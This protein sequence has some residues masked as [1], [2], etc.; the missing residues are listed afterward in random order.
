MELDEELP[1]S[2]EELERA[3]DM[4]LPV[5]AAAPSKDHASVC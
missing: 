1:G 4:R 5:N 2:D 3:A